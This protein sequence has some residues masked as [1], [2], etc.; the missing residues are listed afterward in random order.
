MAGVD[1]DPGGNEGEQGTT[2]RPVVARIRPHELLSL[3]T[4]LV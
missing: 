1:G 4:V 2:E 3:P